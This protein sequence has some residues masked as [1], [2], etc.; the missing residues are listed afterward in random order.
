MKDSFRHH[1]VIPGFAKPFCKVCGLRLSITIVL[2]ARY[3]LMF[4]KSLLLCVVLVMGA[5][6]AQPLSA[7]HHLPVISKIHLRISLS[8]KI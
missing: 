1:F 7:T 2:F 8:P 4:V 5:N 6:H 3:L